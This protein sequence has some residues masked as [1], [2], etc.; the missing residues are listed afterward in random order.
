[1]YT[2]ESHSKVN[3]IYRIVEVEV[4]KLYSTIA[5]IISSEILTVLLF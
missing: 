4:L 2:C 5:G 3:I 1:M